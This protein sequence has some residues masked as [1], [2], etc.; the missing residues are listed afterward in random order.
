MKHCAFALVTMI[1]LLS[2]CR[3]NQKEDVREL[4]NREV[5][6]AAAVTKQVREE[7]QAEI[8]D[9]LSRLKA[10]IDGVRTKVA[11]APA[12]SNPLLV[13][14]LNEQANDLEEEV[15]AIRMQFD[16]LKTASDEQFQAGKLDVK[17]RLEELQQKYNRF[18]TGSSR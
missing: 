1:L 18:A 9:K 15:M 12:G 4:E 17:N 11:A 14:E 7:F 2:S 6:T 8:E 3:Q 10:S 5:N 16:Q 13:K